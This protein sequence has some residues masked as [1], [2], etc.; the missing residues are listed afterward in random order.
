M[1]DTA[2]HRITTLAELRAIVGEENE[3]TKVKIGN[4]IDQYAR[5]FI[6]RSP[7]LVLSGRREHL[8]PFLPG[9]AHETPRARTARQSPARWTLPG[10][11]DADSKRLDMRS[12]S[13]CY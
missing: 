11:W 12:C 1:T 9:V 2:G 6:S 4:T 13:W 3:A 10:V 7:F 8:L 5:V